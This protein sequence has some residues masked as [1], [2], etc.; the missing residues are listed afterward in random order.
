MK[1]FVI[2]LIKFYQ[3]HIS[4]HLPAQC[5]FYPTCSAY[6]VTAIEYYGVFKG[7]LMTLWRLLRCNPMCKGGYDPVPVPKHLRNDNNQD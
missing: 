2:S 4:S 7:G 3:K 5:R 6:A 1:D